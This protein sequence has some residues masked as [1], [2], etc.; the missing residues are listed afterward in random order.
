MPPTFLALLLTA[1]PLGT[2]DDWPQW[3]GPARTGVSRERGWSAKPKG[4]LWRSELGLGYSSVAVVG[5][6]LYT[7]GH[8]KEL[9]QDLVFCLDALSGEEVWTHAFPS[10]LMDLYHGGGTLTTPSV[11]GEYVYVSEREGK[12]F[13]LR[14]KDGSVVWEKDAKAEFELDV[15]QW[16]FSASPLVRGDALILNYGRVIAFDRKSGK[17]LWK[18]KKGYGDAYSTPIELALGG[19]DALAVF[20]GAGLVVLSPEDGAERALLPWKT[21]YD[22]NAMTPLVFGERVFISSGYDHGC[23]LVDLAGAEPKIVWESKV[24]RN[25]MSG[26]VPWEGHLYGFDDKVLKC[27]DLE[28]KERW[29]TRGLGQGSLS[30]ADGRLIVI[31]EDGELIVAEAAPSEFK[32]LARTKVFD[33]GICWTVPVLANGVIYARN[34]A[35]EL[36][37][38]DHRP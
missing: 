14:A 37:A 4:E 38:L 7:L 12:L 13:C 26:A 5:N 33:G 28:G 11:E 23:A 2:P 21:Q 36:A 6:R 18:T 27:I 32:E 3:G 20:A 29:R 30:I 35:G 1:L 17:P 25:Q 15:P 16:G 34:H 19:K 24:M 31:S 9:E 10:K 22:V 8:D